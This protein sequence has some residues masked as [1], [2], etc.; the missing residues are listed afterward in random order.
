VKFDL[1]LT[2]SQ[3]ASFNFLVESL[4]C[5]N[6]SGSVDSIAI[7]TLSK[8]HQSFQMQSNE[9]PKSS[10]TFTQL[11]LPHSFPFL[12][13]PSPTQTMSNDKLPLDKFQSQNFRFDF[14]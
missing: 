11:K 5:L 13:Q 10:S 4:D 9:S 6:L 12:L 2:R 3:K 1:F 7:P 8:A 14:M